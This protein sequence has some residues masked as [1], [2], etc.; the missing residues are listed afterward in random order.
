MSRPSK[1]SLDNLIPAKKGEPS[2][3]PLG[4]SKARAEYRSMFEKIMSEEITAGSK[5]ITIIE[6]TI[7]KLIEAALNRSEPWA[8]QEILDKTLGKNFTLDMSE[9]T[10]NVLLA[11]L[12][13]HASRVEGHDDN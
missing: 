7:R 6:A 12:Q 3:N 9:D 5:R 13:G 4:V 10:Q 1:R 2:R 8:I 11:Y